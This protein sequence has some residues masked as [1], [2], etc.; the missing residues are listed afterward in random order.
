[1][2]SQPGDGKIPHHFRLL[3]L[4]AELR[5][6][7]FAFAVLSDLPISPRVFI[8]RDAFVLRLP[9]VT[10]VN[11]QV[12]Q[13]SLPLYFEVNTF[14][15]NV[16]DVMELPLAQDLRYEKKLLTFGAWCEAAGADQFRRIRHYSLKTSSA[17]SAP[18]VM[19]DLGAS[20]Q[21]RMEVRCYWQGGMRKRPRLQIGEAPEVLYDVVRGMLETNDGK[22]LLPG[23]VVDLCGE[24]QLCVPRMLHGIP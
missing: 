6:H 10:H 23:D 12:R 15:F 21:F 5:E 1:M 3:D 22:G 13:E 19:L 4:P 14:Q 24:V 2:P 7:I 16:K 11:R 9:A 20:R 8:P 17:V 18:A